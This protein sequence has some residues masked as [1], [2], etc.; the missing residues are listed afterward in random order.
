M[1]GLNMG[2]IKDLPIPLAPMPLQQE[3]VR[4]SAEIA[5][6]KAAHR[7]SS[8]GLDDLFYSLKHRAF[9]GEL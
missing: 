6:L 1:A 4:R 7:Q 8:G 2:I 3:F 5:R 9:R